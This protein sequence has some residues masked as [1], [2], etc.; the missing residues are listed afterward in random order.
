MNER[1]LAIDVGTQSVRAIVFDL[2]GDLCAS[3]QIA[4]EPYFS[5]QPGWA[6][7]DSTLYWKLIGQACQGLWEELDPHSISGMSLTTQ[8][9]TMVCIGADNQPL[10]P[11]IVWMDKRQALNQAPIGGLWGL[12]FRALGLKSTIAQ[13]QAEAPANWLLQHEPEL[14]AKTQ[15]YVL[16]SGYLNFQL[17]GQWQDSIGSQVGYLPFDYKQQRWAGAHDWKWQALP[18]IRPA[19]LPELVAPGAPMGGLCASAAEHLGLPSGLPVIASAADKACEVL[20]AGCVNP[21]QAC[22][23]FGTTATINTTVSKYVEVEKFIPPFPAAVPDSFNTEVQIY[24]GFWMVSWFKRQFADREQRIADERGIAAEAL[25]DELLDSVPPG[26]MGLTL[27]P[28]WSPGVREPGPEAKGAIIG[29]GDVH[30]R[31]HV[32]RAILEGLA[33]GLREGAEKVARRSAKLRILRVA[34]GGS[35][36]NGAMQLTADIFGMAAQR[37]HVYETSALG[38]AINTAVGQGLYAD[39]PAAVSAMTRVKDVFEPQPDAVATYDALYRRVYQKMYAR[40]QP[41]YQEIRDI[42]GYPP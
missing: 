40:L 2:N 7:Q 34:G 35:Q 8:R 24:R 37:P 5:T 18:G 23:S 6:E 42:T 9:A 36:S 13:F 1:L 16:L 39:Y 17:T 25:F 14:W 29:F 3:R 20:G 27:Q 11:A 22:L 38:A 28:Y 33:Y 15:R 21:D 41:L 31:A 19:Q 10:R 30:T 12:A 4:L 26:A 32:Y